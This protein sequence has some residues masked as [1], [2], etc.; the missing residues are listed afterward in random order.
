[1]QKMKIRRN[2]RLHDLV[3]FYS[4]GTTA[5]NCSLFLALPQSRKYPS[6]RNPHLSC[7]EPP[8]LQSRAHAAT[9]AT[10]VDDK[11]SDPELE[12]LIHHLQQ[13]RQL[14]F[15]GY[16]R[17]S[18]RRR[19]RQR[20]EQVGCEDF[21]TYRAFVDANPQEFSDLLNMV[22]INVTSF[23]RDPDAWEVLSSE[24]IPQI[25]ERRREGQ[26]IRIWSVG[27]ASGQEPYSAAM[28]LSEALG[29]EGFC[30]N[31]KIYANDLDESALRAAR[32]ATYSA[33][34]VESVPPHLLDKYFECINGH[35]V[36]HREL[37][38]CVIFGR[39]NIVN[40]AP[41]SRVDLLICR[42]LL[43]YLDAATQNVVLPRLH[44]ALNVGGVLF[45]GKAETQLARSKLFEPVNLKSRL[46]RK[47]SLEWQRSRGGTLSNAA[48]VSQSQH[49]K[50]SQMRL[51]EAIVDGGAT[52]YIAVGLDGQ[53]MLANA[54]AR[55]LLEIG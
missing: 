10:M 8:A 55:R 11:A 52:A 32:L 25:V 49:Q 33:R 39:H 46:F 14:D 36:F 24:I 27:C 9:E 5:P 17:T 29:V 44:Y 47:V 20:M 41:I 42:N 53:V 19:I 1:M 34:E 26:Q 3:E 54:M 31:V 51:L 38:K 40:D 22:L 28:L 12:D 37:R 35:Y 43:I 50:N 2:V 45:L 48:G 4:G 6:S 30:S 18:L 15:R 16:K 23:F 13:T 21:T 7:G